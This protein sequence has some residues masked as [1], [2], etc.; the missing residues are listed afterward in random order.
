[1]CSL[2]AC[3]SPPQ[4]GQRYVRGC[5]LCARR[6]VHQRGSLPDGLTGHSIAH[7][8]G[9]LVLGVSV[10]SLG[11]CAPALARAQAP[12]P[13]DCATAWNRGA[14]PAQKRS[15]LDATGARV[16]ATRSSGACTVTFVLPK[17]G[18]RVATGTPV[19]APGGGSGLWT[20]RGGRLAF[21][22]TC[23]PNARLDRSGALHLL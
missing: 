7:V 2:I 1:M 10:L 14:S 17:R 3:S 12:S 6:N 9:L 4:K 16:A 5:R 21:G 13:R 11:V 22:A 15:V 20:L 8:R 18:L 19:A 23:E